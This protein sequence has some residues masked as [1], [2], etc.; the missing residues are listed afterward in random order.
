MY[1]KFG[2]LWPFYGKSLEEFRILCHFIHEKYISKVE[3]VGANFGG[4]KF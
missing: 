1:H 3:I 4:N 2:D